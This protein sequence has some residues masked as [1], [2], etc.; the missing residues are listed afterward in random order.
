M[1]DKDEKTES[2]ELPT[3]LNDVLSEAPVVSPKA[4]AVPR[5][6]VKK[7]EVKEEPKAEEKE[8]QEKPEKEEFEFEC[9]NCG[10]E[11]NE[12]DYSSRPRYCPNCGIEFIFD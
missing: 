2:L 8:V 5:A 3:D 6:E 1:S 11:F 9:E 4:K 7:E 12:E 10:F